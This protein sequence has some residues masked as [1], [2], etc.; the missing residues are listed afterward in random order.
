MI[1]KEQAKNFLQKFVDS[2]T[3]GSYGCSWIGAGYSA[4]AKAGRIFLYDQDLVET[5]PSLTFESK[6]SF[7]NFFRI[8]VPKKTKVR[9]LTE[10]EFQDCFELIFTAWCIGK[11]VRTGKVSVKPTGEIF[12]HNEHE[13]ATV[14]KSWK[15][16]GEAEYGVDGNFKD[17][18]FGKG[19]SNL[20]DFFDL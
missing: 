16:F 7:A 19:R 20:V 15:E 2:E 10:Q 9:H 13:E 6:E 4:S 3:E 12:V 8:E 5:S 11:T 17:T 14:Y 1:T 18:D